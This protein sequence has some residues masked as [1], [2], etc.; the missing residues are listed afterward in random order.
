MFLLQCYSL[1][2]LDE[3][4]DSIQDVLSVAESEESLYSI[5]NTLNRFGALCDGNTN[6][7]SADL[8]SF[9][10]SSSR[11]T[12]CTLNYERTRLPG[13]ATDFVTSTS[14]TATTALGSPFGPPALFADTS[15]PLHMHEQGV[16]QPRQGMYRRSR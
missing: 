6:T 13:A 8:V 12:D 10:S 7:Y 5:A 1:S 4:F 3:E 14:T 16:P 2:H 11:P 15:H 9:L